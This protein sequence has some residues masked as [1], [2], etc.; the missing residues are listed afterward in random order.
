M[1]SIID[2]IEGSEKFG[3]T[4]RGILAQRRI[5]GEVQ[6]E[7]SGVVEVQTL[8]VTTS[9]IGTISNFTI[10]AKRVIVG[11]FFGKCDGKV[12]IGDKPYPI[13]MDEDKNL[14]IDHMDCKIYLSHD[15]KNTG[16]LET[17]FGIRLIFGLDFSAQRKFLIPGIGLPIRKLYGVFNTS[18]DSLS[19]S[20]PSEGVVVSSELANQQKVTLSPEKF[21]NSLVSKESFLDAI[22]SGMT[23][24]APSTQVQDRPGLKRVLNGTSTK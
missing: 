21:W 7:G 9:Y 10:A 16:R 5:N 8:D 19:I 14:V 20:V 11:D 17:S 6:W 12:F 3:F 15:L 22:S 23:G 1:P 13:V 4:F 24:V 18:N 2:H